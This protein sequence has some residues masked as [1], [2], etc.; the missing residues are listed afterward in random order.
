MEDDKVFCKDCDN[1]KGELF[2][3]YAYITCVNEI[4]GEKYNTFPD[5]LIVAYGKC[6]QEFQKKALLLNQHE[7]LNAN[8]YCKH[9]KPKP[10]LIPKPTLFQKIKAWLSK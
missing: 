1:W 9:F 2:G 4:T 5:E 10:E 8:N 3:C 7:I 6:K